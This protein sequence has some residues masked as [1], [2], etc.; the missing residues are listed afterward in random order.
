MPSK[1]NAVK[2]RRPLP[3]SVALVCVL[4]LTTGCGLI[5]GSGSDTRTVKIWLMQDSVSEEFLDRFSKEYEEKHPSVKL[6]FTFQPWT[7]IGKKVNAALEGED[8]PDIIEVGNTQVAQYAET[9]ALEDLTLES[10]RDLGGEDWLEGL[11][12]PGNIDGSQYG[13]PWYAANRVVI[14]NKDVFADAGIKKTPKTRDEWLA[15]TEQLNQDGT[16]GIYLPGQDWYTLA[17]FIWDEGGDLAV[18]RA[19]SWEGMLHTD[20]TLRG[21]DF[22]KEL[23]ELGQGP[24]DSDETKPPQGE[25]F[26]KGNVAQIVAPP[27]VASTILKANPELEDKLG[28]FTIPGK[29]ADKAG[30]VFTGGSDLIIPQKAEERGAAIEVVKALAGER[31][32]TDLARTMNYV[33]NKKSLAKVVQGEES[34]A[35]MAAGAAAEGSQ[36]TPNSAQW[37]D[38]E[39]ENPIK[40]FMTKVLEGGDP[41]A[42]GREASK[43]ITSLLTPG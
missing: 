38:V 15:M 18:E 42:A 27:S 10:V 32:Q 2:I 4:A 20:A 31:W 8:T 7:G 43:R 12:Q 21:M 19:G 13:I 23:Q 33:P 36:A 6:E 16:Q 37:A 24:K 17:G 30:A 41:E 3:P 29:T 40:P 14:Y 1:V 34:T 5:P 26:A 28:Y 11:A 39:I 9:D 22:Y 35:A 25:V